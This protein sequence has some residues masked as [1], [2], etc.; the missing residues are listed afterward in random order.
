[1]SQDFVFSFYSLLQQQNFFK[2]HIFIY[3]IYMIHLLHKI[4]F[5]EKSTT[6]GNCAP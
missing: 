6:F 2:R 3:Y 1:M 5:K 4:F